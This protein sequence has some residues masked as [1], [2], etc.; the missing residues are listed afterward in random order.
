MRLPVLERPRHAQDAPEVDTRALQRQL[1]DSVEGEVR[2]DATSRAAYSTD[3]SNYRRIPVGVIAPKSESDVAATLDACRAH[4][5]PL[6]SRGGGTSLDGQCVTHGLVMDFSKHMREILDVDP[7]ARTARVQPGVVLDSLNERTI[8]DHDLAFAPDPST[9]SHCTLGGMLGNNSCGVHSILAGR[10]SDNVIS[11]R[12]MTSDGAVLQLEELDEPA[13]E[14]ACRR[15][16]REG[17][18][19]AALRALRNRHAD[20][21][22]ERYPDIPRRVSGFNLADLL[23]E[24]GFSAARALVGSEGTCAVILEATVRL[25]DWPKHRA[26]LVLGYPSVYDAGDHVPEILDAG[27]MGLEGLDERL[28]QFMRLK[29]LHPA[30]VRMLPGGKGWLLVEFGGDS[31]QEAKD[32]AAALMDRLRAHDRPPHMELIDEPAE[33]RRI[34]EV[35][36]AGLGATAFV[37]GMPDTWPGWEDAAVPPERVGD[38]LRDFRTLVQESG[39]DCALYGH[40]GQ[41][42]IHCRINFDLASERGIQQ[43]RD[44]VQRA[45]DLCVRHGGS[46]SGEHGDAISKSEL[47][48]RMFGD[49]LMGAFEEFKRIWDPQNLLNPGK[50][51]D[52]P[53]ATRDLRI[54][55]HYT[56]RRMPTRLAYGEAGKQSFERASIRCVGVGKCRRRHHAFMCPSYEATQEE[57]HTT[58]GRARL[59]FE[60]TRGD[61]IADGWRSSAVLESLDLCLAC[62]GCKKECPVGVDLASYKAEFLHHHYRRRIRP[63][64]HYTMGHIGAAARAASIAPGLANALAAAPLTGPALK[65]FAGIAPDRDMPRFARRTFTSWFRHHRRERTPS[66]G[67]VLLL[68]DA[69]NDH[70]FPHTLR[71][72]LQTLETLGHDV[73][74]PDRRFPAIRPLVHYG[75]LALSERRLRTLIDQLD[76]H[77]REGVPLIGLEPSSVAVLRDEAASFFPADPAARRVAQQTR[78]LSEFLA[79]RWLDALPRVGGRAVFHAHCHQKAVLDAEAPRRVLDAMGVEV[80]EPEPG[81]CGMAG[82]FG[83]ERRHADLSRRIGE[84]RL[85]PAVRRAADSDAVIIEGFSC[86]EQI[87]QDAHRKPTHLAEFVASALRTGSDQS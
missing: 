53:S 66:R 63:R 82:S 2:F 67:P 6:V 3:A 41:G 16:G 74:I 37:P 68:P 5:V 19:H 84:M 85:L 44:F 22:R 60:M 73:R 50:I 46:L 33:E 38:Y 47:L 70:F 36:E 80:D 31:R 18:L 59:L 75:F 45:A 76:A 58:R 72:A 57:I 83:F 23:P 21:I 17:E 54:G 12:V 43:Y 4:A 86:R 34:W 30:E 35:R 42:C 78:L 7:A 48:P 15:P 87:S 79:D 65:W 10:T 61:F 9:H 55:A 51:V 40:F 81:C 8:P 52:A 20:A 25:V 28:V 14:R 24:R 11:M 26:L 71:A 69:F 27:P 32:A 64:A 56:P 29:G 62:K 77:A 1:Q 39:Y 13:L 49:Q